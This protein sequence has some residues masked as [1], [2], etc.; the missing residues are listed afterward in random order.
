MA[1]VFVSAQF[2]HR[3]FLSEDSYAF[4]KYVA[5]SYGVTAA[6]AVLAGAALLGFLWK[7][8]GWLV[9]IGFS[10]APALAAFIEMARDKTSHNLIPLE[11][12][13]YW[14]PIFIIAW[15]GAAVGVKI[16]VPKK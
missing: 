3:T 15:V 5:A 11:V 2:D 13:L 12:I 10:L 9:A 4:T 8:G 16:R 14:L 6:I 1:I 7:S